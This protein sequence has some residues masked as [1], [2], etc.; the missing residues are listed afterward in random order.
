[1]RAWPA[2][3]AVLCLSACSEPPLKEVAA[4]EAR[5][6]EARQAGAARF[7]PE[8]LKEAEIALQTARQKIDAKDYR[9]AL[10]AASD[11]A[12]KSKGAAQAA[13]AAKTRARGAAERAQA[14]VQAVLDQVK[15]VRRDA[16]ERKVPD[17][18]FDSLRNPVD[19]ARKVLDTVASA[20]ERG[21]FAEAEKMAADLKEKV[22][23]LPRLHRD[24]MEKWQAAHGRR[25]P[26]KRS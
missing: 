23:P 16:T 12:D 10:S 19:A 1:M 14:E 17:K 15:A 26:A 22:T 13:E 18:V 21:E 5:L 8:R 25:P 9:G 11:A 24:A 7:A 6:A 3:L 20:I 2:I 4:A